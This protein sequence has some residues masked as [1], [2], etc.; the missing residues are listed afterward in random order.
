MDKLI[1][2]ILFIGIPMALT[3]L[4]YR[5]IDHK[6]NKTAK[7]AERFP[8]LVKR[9]FLVQIGGAM[10]FVI[11]FGLISLL[12]DLPIKVFFIV[13][14]TPSWRSCTAWRSRLC[15]EISRLQRGNWGKIKSCQHFLPAAFF[16]CLFLSEDHKLADDIV[17]YQ[18]NNVCH[19]LCYPIVE[20]EK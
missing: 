7:L 4:I 11:V 13:C 3:Q 10:A 2:A 17:K 19:Y 8:V 16:V 9:K 1:T 5:I 12:L 20:A 15:T 14:S 18:H 6:G